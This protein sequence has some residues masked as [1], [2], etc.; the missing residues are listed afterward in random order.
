MQRS[1]LLGLVRPN[2]Q[3]DRVGASLFTDGGELR[4][5]SVCD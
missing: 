2:E 4:I 3:S 5:F 1:E